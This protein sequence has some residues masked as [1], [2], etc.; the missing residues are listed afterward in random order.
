MLEDAECADVLAAGR[1]TGAARTTHPTLGIGV[2]H[3][4][5]ADRETAG[6]RAAP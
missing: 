2:D 3:D 1:A 5:L 6:P 4:A